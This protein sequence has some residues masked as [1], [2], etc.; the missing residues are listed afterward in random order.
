MSFVVLDTDVAS[1]SLRGRLDDPLRA[2][3]TGLRVININE[4]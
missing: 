3:L 2:G 1:G 4:R